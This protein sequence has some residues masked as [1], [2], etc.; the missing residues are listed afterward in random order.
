MD[1]TNSREKMHVLT[2]V[3][4]PNFGRGVCFLVSLDAWHGSGGELSV[5]RFWP[6]VIVTGGAP[7][8]RNKTTQYRWKAVRLV[9]RWGYP[10]LG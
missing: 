2:V 1:K 3:I 5:G 4:L 9:L 10:F 6:N 7:E 8:L